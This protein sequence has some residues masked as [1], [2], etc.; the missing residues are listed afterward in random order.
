M[1]TA[2]AD[3]GAVPAADARRRGRVH[4]GGG[5]D[6]PP[7]AY[8]DGARAY[9]ACAEV[10]QAFADAGVCGSGAG[11]SYF[12][13]QAQLRACRAHPSF[14]P[15]VPSCTPCGVRDSEAL[16]LRGPPRG[17]A[18]S[19]DACLALCDEQVY[20]TRLVNGS[21]ALSPVPQALISRCESCGQEY[22][23]VGCNNLTLCVDD[24][25]W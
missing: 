1:R 6:R 9:V 19:N 16:V 21:K 25:F 24:Y 14:L 23:L 20:F 10:V 15:F 7:A 2:G 17:M 13:V 11:E 3:A 12:D 5:R 8:R 22:H 4:C 18:L